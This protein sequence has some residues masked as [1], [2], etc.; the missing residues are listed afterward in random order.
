MNIA[1]LWENAQKL[2]PHR[3]S[4]EEWLRP[5]LERDCA[6]VLSA[7]ERERK[8]EKLCIYY[9]WH[10]LEHQGT[11]CLR[12]RQHQAGYIWF[13]PGE[14]ERGIITAP[15]GYRPIP[16]Y[17]YEGIL[18]EKC[19][20]LT[21]LL[22]ERYRTVSAWIK[23]EEWKEISTKDCVPLFTPEEIIFPYPKIERIIERIHAT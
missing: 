19:D 7:E 13:E 10:Y 17:N 12:R 23:E 21:G 3:A 20:Q 6:L 8:G 14:A 11:S 16:Q 5:S 15:Q 22:K 4:L 18:Q 1:H 9:I 2:E